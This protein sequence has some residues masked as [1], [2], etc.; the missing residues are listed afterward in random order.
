MKNAPSEA[1][2]GGV[3]YLVD[4]GLVDSVVARGRFE[5]PTKGL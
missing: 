3:L 1:V 5:L 2:G 4:I